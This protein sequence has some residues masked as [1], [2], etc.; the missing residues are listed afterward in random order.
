MKKILLSVVALVVM[1]SAQAVNLKFQFDVFSSG[2]SLYP[3][4]AGIAHAGYQS[5]VCYDREN[6]TQSCNPHVA[7][8]N[9]PDA[10]E[11]NCVCTGDG[12]NN[13]QGERRLDFM[14]ASY[15]KWK[16][17]QFT[18]QGRSTT[19]T[20]IASSSANNY[21]TIFP[22]DAT[23]SSAK[24]EKFFKKQLRSLSFNLG[25][26]RYGSRYFLDVCFRGPQIDYFGANINALNWTVKSAVTVQD[27]SDTKKKYQDLAGLS[28][29]SFVVCD[30]QD[31]AGDLANNKVPSFANF[32]V[33]YDADLINYTSLANADV[34]SG[35]NFQAGEA[36]S[37]KRAPKFCVVRYVFKEENRQGIESLRL[38]K[39]Q[40]AKICTE[41][42]FNEPEL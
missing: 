14:E 34:A 25:S 39:K 16:D 24:D 37:G 3:C 10:P 5:R 26:E 33:D 9:T 18:S 17:N 31:F 4:N 29:E 8:P 28:V 2:D 32:E 23:A 21:N 6:P 30:R 41:T 7:C 11:C 27:L 22:T 38:W 1:T 35:N 19:V 13:G 15:S 20:Q 12:A 36:L 42:T 40:H